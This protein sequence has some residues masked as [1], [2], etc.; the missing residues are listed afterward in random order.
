MIRGNIIH[1]ILGWVDFTVNA[2][3]ILNVNMASPYPEIVIGI[4]TLCFSDYFKKFALKTRPLINIIR[5]SRP[6]IILPFCFLLFAL[7][8][9]ANTD[10]IVIEYVFLIDCSGSMEWDSRL[11]DDPQQ[12]G[13]KIFLFEQIKRDILNI[14]KNIPESQEALIHLMPFDE[15]IHDS[16]IFAI[17]PAAERTWIKQEI[18]NYLYALKANGQQTYLFSSLKQVIGEFKNKNPSSKKRFLTTIFILSDGIDTE[19]DFPDNLKTAIEMF[20]DWVDQSTEKPWLYTL[21]ILP[22]NLPE[23]DLQKLK[24]ETEAFNNVKQAKILTTHIGNEPRIQIIRLRLSEIDFG[25][26]KNGDHPPERTLSFDYITTAT[27]AEEIELSLIPVIAHESDPLP[28]GMDIV[29][30]RIIVT[31]QVKG[32]GTY[33]TAIRLQP[34]LI[35]YHND[36][37]S[38]I[39]GFFDVRS[40][41]GILL[42]PDSLKWKLRIGSPPSILLQPITNQNSATDKFI[43]GNQPAKSEYIF[44]LKRN[45]PINGFITCQIDLPA[46]DSAGPQL[47]LTDDAGFIKSSWD[48]TDLSR[49]DY[50][51]LIFDIPPNLK[52]GVL[53]GNFIFD[54]AP[55]SNFRFQVPGS[56]KYAEKIS[57]P[58]NFNI[59][60]PPEPYWYRL[61]KFFAGAVLVLSFLL[62][63]YWYRRPEFQDVEL[64]I[65]NTDTP[66]Q[67]INAKIID[68]LTLHGKRPITIGQGS[69]RLEIIEAQL[70]FLTER[71]SD[72]EELRVKQAFPHT[73]I[74]HYRQSPDTAS[75]RLIENAEK[76]FKVVDGD[77]LSCNGLTIRIASVSYN[78]VT[79]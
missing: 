63:T 28:T 76:E 54:A 2:M 15:K 29:F 47:Q 65:L 20:T 74:K 25:Y 59:D 78:G 17:P 49:S 41:D 70:I 51:K 77:M 62:G 73:S 16:K 37:N 22:K 45:G 69:G 32:P 14:V 64:Q 34:S 61:S 68:R 13:N 5:N 58:F 7:P 27:Q 19:P 21:H 48:S 72:G 42:Q 40:A 23:K 1:I 10:D 43:Y 11:I 26:W 6:L 31:S 44:R 3:D 75:W 67:F 4:L 52:P 35:N 38:F 30:K 46:L 12:P 24:I 57:I 55:D 53:K 8:A 56:D 60:K 50:L 71:N 39:A 36:R 9:K 33:T 18:Q 79:D 66:E